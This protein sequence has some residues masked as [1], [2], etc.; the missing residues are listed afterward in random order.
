MTERRDAEKERRLLTKAL[1]ST[2]E[3][4][5][6]FDATSNGRLIYV[7]EGACRMLGY[8]REELLNMGI[9]GVDKEFT[10]ADMEVGFKAIEQN[11]YFEL[12]RVHTAKEGRK[13]QVQITSS[14]FRVGEHAYILATARDITA[15]KEA[16]LALAK[17]E[18]RYRDIFENSR[19][20][21]YVLDVTEAGR[22]L[23]VDVNSAF[24][25]S[26]G[27]KREALAGRYVEE[28][29]DA[30]TAAAVIAK[31]R[32]CVEAG[33]PTEEEI[34]L[35]LP[36]G[37]RNYR[38]T[39]IPIR[40]GKTGRV[41]RIVGMTEDITESKEAKRELA[42]INFALDHVREAAI[43]ADAT[44]RFRYVNDEACRMLGYSREELLQLGI[45]DID[46]DWSAKE[47]PGQL[48]ALKTADFLKFK[49]R[50]RS[51]TGRTFPVEILANYFEFEGEAY[52]LGIIREIEKKPV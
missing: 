52:N 15:K 35:E 43:L 20:A 30:E 2:Q 37:R 1:D 13:I 44:A 46:P 23:N 10:Q 5:W 39:L 9:M 16:Q 24:E 19:D 28:T 29:V 33:V 27:M 38:S 40:D 4:V 48:Q 11:G 3:T 22:F 32:R 7:N 41:H 21:L 51:K 14:L 49:G 47:W 45:G 12:E 6:L 50:H 18:R 25:R 17:S 34:E 36:V 42:L 26:T 8:T 31:Y